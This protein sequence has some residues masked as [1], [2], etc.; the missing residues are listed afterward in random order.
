MVDGEHIVDALFTAVGPDSVSEIALHAESEAAAEPEDYLTILAQAYDGATPV[1]GAEFR[2][3]LDGVE[4]FGEG[5]LYHYT[6]DPEAP[7]TLSAELDG[8]TDEVRIHG[9]GHVDSTN[10]V[11]CS[12]IGATSGGIAGLLVGLLGITRRRR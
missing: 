8:L 3:S 10:N 12:A 1:Y 11:G 4:E 7:Y 2:W 5:D 6:Y 9:E